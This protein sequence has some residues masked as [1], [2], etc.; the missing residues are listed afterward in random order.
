MSPTLPIEVMITPHSV[1]FKPN[2]VRLRTE[3]AEN[4]MEISLSDFAT[5]PDT[6]SGNRRHFI[7]GSDARIIMSPDEAALIR[8][9]KAKHTARPSRRICQT[10]SSS[11]GVAAEAPSGLGVERSGQSRRF[12][13][14]R[15]AQAHSVSGEKLD[16]GASENTFDYC[17]RILVSHVAADLDV[18]DCISVESGRARE[19]SN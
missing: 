5:L 1:L 4:H 11:N 3:E 8:L 14:S 7:G 15:F 13:S 18:A 2:K 9:G 16:A 12:H 10:I 6:R 17:Q 19:V